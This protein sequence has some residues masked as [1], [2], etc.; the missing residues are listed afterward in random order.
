MKSG[1]LRVAYIV[2]GWPGRYFISTSVYGYQDLCEIR[3]TTRAA[4]AAA[5]DTTK[6]Y[7]YGTR[8]LFLKRP[9][10]RYAY[11]I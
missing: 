1:A 7:A 9:Y 10:V 11:F 2:R 8:V 6:T 4:A 3:A 5:D